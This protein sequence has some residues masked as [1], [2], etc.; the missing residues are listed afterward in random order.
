MIE[1]SME[2]LRSTLDAGLRWMFDTEQPPAA[3]LQHHGTSLA[4]PNNRR[5]RFCP[6][7]WGGHPVV[8]LNVRRVQYGPPGLGPRNPL[9]AGELEL[10]MEAIERSG[11]SEVVSTWNGH[12]P[13]TASVALALSLI[14]I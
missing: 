14:H 13:V 12:P 1:S 6:V 11:A 4:C 7:G 10:L 3:I 5:L 8:V 9:A 2:P